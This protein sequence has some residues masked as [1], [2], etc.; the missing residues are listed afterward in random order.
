MCTSR[1]SARLVV[2]ALGLLALGGAAAA[3]TSSLPSVRFE[4]ASIKRNQQAEAE[5]AAIPAGVTVYAARSQTLR[6]GLFLGRGMSARELIR[7]A[8]GYRNRPQSDLVG[9]PG[10]IDNERYD[11]EAKADVDFPA[12]SSVGLPP[13]GQAALRALLAERFNLKVRVE[14][15]R[16][17][18][19]EL[20]LHR[21]DG[22]LG[23]NLVPAKGGC[24]SFFE[25]EPVNVGLVIYKP[26]DGEPAPARPCSTA[27]TANAILAEN[28][29]LSDWVRILQVRPQINRTV[30]D[31]TGLS[32]RYDITLRADVDARTAGLL[33][34][35]KPWMESQL[36][37]TLRDAEAPVEIL[38]IEHIDR[39][40]E[41]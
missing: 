2:T 19:Y 16:R 11:V 38:V 21:A 28:M 23:P 40:T 32:G 39:P 13:A 17:P 15:L 6:G 22:R 4:V 33:P 26:A 7:D 14:L 36:G 31:R 10:W 30:I 1:S 9:A 12:S 41:N 8:Y 37:L 29:T 5:R 25:R 18:V 20:V 35:L 27:A 3:Q 24:Q 34:P